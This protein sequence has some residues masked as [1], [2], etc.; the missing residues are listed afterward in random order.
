MTFSVALSTPG[1][2]AWWLLWVSLAIHVP[3]A[4]VAVGKSKLPNADLD[5]FYDIGTRSG[6]GMRRRAPGWPGE[7]GWN[8]ETSRSV[9]GIRGASCSEQDIG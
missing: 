6:R 3:I 8:D 2:L 1:R 9:H 4:V 7:T 5:N